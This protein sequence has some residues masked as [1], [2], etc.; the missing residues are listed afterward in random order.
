MKKTSLYIAIAIAIVVAIAAALIGTSSFTAKGSA[1]ATALQQQGQTIA[2]A[3]QAFRAKAGRPAVQ[4]PELVEK[5][6]LPALPAYPDAPGGVAGAPFSL[7]LT[8]KTYYAIADA[9]MPAE[10]STPG[11]ADPNSTLCAAIDAAATKIRPDTYTA[12]KAEELV[13]NPATGNGT[14][15][16]GILSGNPMLVLPGAGPFPPLGHYIFFYKLD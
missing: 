2:T 11:K 4:V 14:F 9:G 15:G 12:Q 6:F 1:E 7:I 3:W 5:G 16:C 10:G 8:N 13:Q